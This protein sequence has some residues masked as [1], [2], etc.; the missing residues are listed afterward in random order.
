[1][2]HVIIIV[3]RRKYSYECN[4][5]YIK[6]PVTRQNYIDKLHAYLANGD[7]TVD[8]ASAGQVTGPY[9]ECGCYYCI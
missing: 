3:T 5:E 6:K 1:M 7:V 2:A 8:N 4:H 9:P